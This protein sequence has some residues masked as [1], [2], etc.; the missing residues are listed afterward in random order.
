MGWRPPQPV[1]GRS[2][3]ESESRWAEEQGKLVFGDQ[4]KVVLG[5]R[6]GGPDVAVLHFLLRVPSFTVSTLPCPHLPWTQGFL[7][8]APPCISAMQEEGAGRVRREQPGSR[9]SEQ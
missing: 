6:P 7:F 4:D 1:D 9:L 2:A 3:Y 8:L 5:T